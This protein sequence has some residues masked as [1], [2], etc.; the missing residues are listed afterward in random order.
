MTTPAPA[1]YF[2]QIQAGTAVI[3][4]LV[5]AGDLAMPIPTCPD[6][7]LRE[8]AVHIGRTHRWAAQITA[9]R[10]REF[11]AFRSVPDG[12]FPD[13]PAARAGWL[14]AGAR[15]AVEA[16]GG[17]GEDPVWAFGG[18]VPASFWARRMCHETLVHQADAVLAAG[19]RPDLPAG[20]AAD[21]VDEWLTELMRPQAGEAD[22]RAAAL[23][24]GASLHVHATDTGGEWLVSH[25]PDGVTAERGH[26]RADVAVAGPAS[27]LLLVLLRRAPADGPD[28]TVHG[29]AAVLARWLAQTPF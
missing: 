29:D 23:P 13:D 28:V 22:P 16:I 1:A 25:G 12:R 20:L 3:A 19:Q 2:A 8:L 11:I 10:S 15:R 4:G 21:A 27:A 14:T 18:L 26:A 17:A 24:P 7:T 9:T 6:W 5:D